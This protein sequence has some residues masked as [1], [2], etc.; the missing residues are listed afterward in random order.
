MTYNKY[1]V[2]V[3]G[4]GP[5]GLAAAVSAAEFGARTVVLEAEAF[6]GGVA[7]TAL[8]GARILN[9]VDPRALSQFGLEDSSERFV[10]DSLAY[11]GNRA[12]RELLER[13]CYS[14]TSLL[15][16]LVS[17]GVQ[18]SGPIFYARNGLWPRAHRLKSEGQGELI[19]TL[20][21]S[22]RRLKVDVKNS[23]EIMNLARSELFTLKNIH[24]ECFNAR[25]VVIACGGFANCKEILN[26]A[27][28]AM[29]KLTSLKVLGR[30]T[31]FG[32]KMLLQLEAAYT[33]LG[34]CELMPSSACAA[35]LLRHPADFILI[36]QEGLRFVAED[37]PKTRLFS[38]IARQ[39]SVWAITSAKLDAL[40][41]V[42]LRQASELH[43][44]TSL[45][46]LVQ[47]I[48][49]PQ[50][51]FLQTIQRYRRHCLAEGSLLHE[52]GAE[53]E[54][55]ILN[56][57]DFFNDGS[58]CAI[59]VQL[60]LAGTLGGVRID[61]NAN[62]IDW[63]RRPLKGIYAAGDVLGGLH[64]LAPVPGNRLLSALLFGRVAGQ[65][66]ALN[67]RS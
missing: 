60:K 34:F 5:A 14:S 56:R 51:K 28:P 47:S 4:A 61:R 7:R 32:L 65:N 11:G 22:A 8:S 57:K 41:H 27:D 52:Q 1:D 39:Q 42:R 63:R 67:A 19:R 43:F 2:A 24:G 9:A 10:Q 55:S 45:T 6:S 29:A 20:E 33:G 30:Q 35:E 66:A 13:M 62:V 12:D 36:N 31:G 23:S 21:D 38:Q 18:F 15:E 26:K 54:K 40:K 50:E 53:V 64:G 44:A 46:A 25:T 58:L 59:P 49:V 3:V 37:Q 48:S 17:L 16:W